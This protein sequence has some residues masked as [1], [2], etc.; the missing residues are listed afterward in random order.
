MT[1]TPRLVVV[2]LVAFVLAGQKGQAS[3]VDNKR[4]Q[5]LSRQAFLAA[6][7]SEISPDIDH[8][9]ANLSI[10]EII[11]KYG[12]P[13]EIHNI[14]TEDGYVL[15][16]HR[17]PYGKTC[18]PA[19]GKKVAWLQH[20]LLGDSSNYIINGPGKGLGY[21]MADACYDVWIGNFRGNTYSKRHLQWDPKE[22]AKEFWSYSWHEIGIYDVAANIDYALAVTGQESLYYVGHSMGTTTIWVLLSQ[23]PEYNQKIR[24]MSALAP[25]AHT[26]HMISPLRLIAPFEGQL[27]WVINFL[28]LYEFLPSNALMDLLGKTVCH[29]ASPIQLVC[30]NVLFLIAGYNFDQIDPL[31]LSVVLGHSP[32][33]SS[34]GCVLHYGQGVN[35][36]G[37]KLYNYGK[38]ENLIRYGQETPPDYDWSKITAPVALYWGQN[39][40]LAA[41]ADAYR[42]AE[43]LPNLVRFHRVNHDHFN[44]MDFIWAKDVETLVNNL[45]MEYIEKY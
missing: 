5:E 9:D 21:V 1:L 41:P 29:E 7:G 6:S 42:I 11:A 12:Y 33:G 22:N 30:S 23:K 17:I 35:S 15:E 32:A 2:C 27:E 34:S 19:E 31:L 16:A 3:P 45:V 14:T 40:W 37:F 39:D 8:E 13:I 28:G 36:G 26:V 18:G 25:V 4:F 10:P 43:R 24:L 44:H 20:G 38:E